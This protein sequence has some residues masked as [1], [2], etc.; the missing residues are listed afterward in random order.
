VSAA[1]RPAPRPAPNRPAPR[2][3]AR[4]AASAAQPGQ[5]GGG[6]LLA[7]LRLGQGGAQFVALQADENVPLLDQG[8]FVHCH[9]EHPPGQRAAD[10]DSR[11]GRHARR[12]L[13]R[14]QQWRQLHTYRRHARRAGEPPAEH[15]GQQYGENGEGEER[16]AGHRSAGGVA[17]R[18]SVAFGQRLARCGGRR[19]SARS[20][21]HHPILGAAAARGIA[22]H[23]RRAARR[24]A[25][26]AC[27]LIQAT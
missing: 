3:P 21:A 20:G 25:Q 19:R 18:S 11:K 13:Q 15:D 1:G 23:R 14:A 26:A 2:R 27:C 4:D 5:A 17:V 8:A 9:L 7:G 10:I 12:E 22:G 24:A 6:L 16:T